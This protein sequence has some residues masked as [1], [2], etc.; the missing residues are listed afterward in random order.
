MSERPASPSL[1]EAI[2]YH[3]RY[4]LA[5][6]PGEL[7][8]REAC[9]AVAL[10]TRD[11]AVDAMLETDARYDAANVKRVYYLSMEFL[12]G[13]SLENNLSNLGLLE[14]AR[15]AIG[16]VGGDLEA[17]VA[18]EPDA[19]LGNGGLGRLA[20]C[21]LDSMASLGIPGYGY[22]INYEFGLFRQE[23]DNGN[24]REKP[25][26]WLAVGT[27]WQIER[28]EEA[29]LVP[30]YG[31]IE[32][33]QDL[34]GHY[35]P[36]WLDWKV[37]LGVP[38]DFPI[39]GY[40]GRTVN[41]LRLYSARSSQDFDMEIFNLGDYLRAVEQK[42]ASE[43]VSKVLYPSDAVASGR[44]LRLLQEY[45]LVACALRDIVR[46][47]LRRN[48]DVRQLHSRVAIQL[49]DTHPALSVLELM[50]IL[51]DEHA[52]AW[53][54]AW[55]I[56]R[57]TCAY[58]NHT[59]MPE[60]L[61]KWPVALLERVL[62]RH[63]QILY[64]V[65]QRFLDEVRARFPGDDE[66]ACRVSLVQEG[67]NRQV[68]MAHLAIVGSHSVN[69]VAALHSELVRTTLVPDFHALFPE[70]FNNKTNGVTPR[71]WLLS[72]NPP[73]AGLL[74]DTIG[75]A[76][77]SD[78]EKL[79]ALEPLAE[80]AGFRAAF[81][82]AKRANKARLARVIAET[83][84][85]KADPDSLFDIQVKRI[86]EYKR[87]LLNALHVAH[88]YLCLVEDGQEPLWPKTYVFAGKAAPGYWAAKQIIRFITALADTVNRDP[89]TDDLL[90][91]AFVPDYRVSLAEVIIPAGDLS[92]QISTAGTEA[93]GTS[94]MKFAMNGALTVGTMDGAN[95]EI[96]E[97]VGAENVFIFGLRADEITA[98]QQS[99][100]YRPAEIYERDPA[101]RRLLDAIDDGRFSGGDRS[102][103]SW[104]RR[105]L[106][107]SGDRYFHLA[108]F[109]SYCEAQAEASRLFREPEEWSRKAVLN[110]AR[111]GR[112]SSDRSIREY[113][114]EIWGVTPA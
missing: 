97:E 61:E 80:D 40:G 60:A 29:V 103:F 94:N 25:D 77:I 49:N 95:I 30:C 75:D 4:S 72:A 7:S 58:T 109:P 39:V 67:D 43:T 37:L 12:V 5:R 10:A 45:F 78:L 35:N 56:T 22:G 34:E 17:V 110:V 57:A 66:R 65:N 82:S 6:R 114:S 8:P 89:R 76:W 21:F 2:R 85:V 105:T 46:D 90:R 111:M 23:L 1:A 71:R 104:I 64:E 42:I 83:A 54:E 62:P 27:P 28:P 92:E 41:C 48:A 113:A 106:V 84:R 14:E 11:R 102:L 100:S 112:F 68:R 47:Y 107:E 74:R 86:H 98:L 18:A 15:A 81:R 36:L 63:L 88:Q 59:L 31:R 20:A 24:Q 53:D 26:H 70:R 38:H 93:S 51:V 96:R 87:Q 33:S 69:G 101:V 9:R 91:V 19:A 44:E 52:V 73:L 16:A 79:R 3:V 32:H 13:R 99:G 108:D 55:E 50:R